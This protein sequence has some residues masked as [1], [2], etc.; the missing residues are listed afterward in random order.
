[1]ISRKYNLNLTPDFIYLIEAL[2][3]EG[4]WCL[5]NS[6]F[7]IQNKNLPFLDNIERILKNLGMNVYKRILIKLK[8]IDQD[9]VKEDVYLINNNTN[10]SFHI[11]KS[12]FNNYPKIVTSL[13]YKKNYKLTLKIKNITYPIKIKVTK[14]EI[15]VT[16]ELKGWAYQEVRFASIELLKFALKYVGNKKNFRIEPFLFTSSKE[17]IASAFSALIDSERSL[18]HYK[19]A[20][21]VRIRMR[22]KIYLEDWKKLLD[23]FGIYSRLQKNNDKEYELCIQGNTYFAKLEELGLK[24][25]HSKKYS[26]WYGLLK[27]YKR[28]QIPRNTAYKFYIERLKEFDNP[29]TAIYLAKKLKKSKRVVSHYLN[30]LMRKNLI[31]VYKSPMIYLYTVK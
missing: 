28:M 20:R 16:S 9:F 22:N 10:L 18:N 27:S 26:K 6:S 19:H 3:V 24:L 21:R 31:T 25:H 11:E 5:S 8:P 12:P 7:F 29:V 15:R 1:M 2:K 4:S 17:H 30:K 14:E 23:N 13:P